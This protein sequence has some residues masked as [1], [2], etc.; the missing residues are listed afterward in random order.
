MIQ[1]IGEGRYRNEYLPKKAQD[2]DYVI[3]CKG[4]EIWSAIIEDQLTYLTYGEVTEKIPAL[5]GEETYLFAIDGISY[6][7]FREGAGGGLNIAGAFENAG[8]EGYGWQ[9]FHAVRYTCPGVG[10][11]A[12]ITAAQISQWY[13]NRRFCPHCGAPMEHSEKERM[14][15]CPSCKLT[16]YPKISP[17]VIVG[18]T[19]GDKILLTKYAGRS[20]TRYALIA[21]FYEVGETIEETVHREVMEEVGLRVKNLRYY[22]SQPWSVSDSLLMGFF[23]DVDG[24]PTIHLDE[25]ELSVGVWCSRDEIPEDDGISLTREMMTVFKNQK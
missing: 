25:E 7:L 1:D 13:S 22:K 9:N 19:N 24:D 8:F 4:R 6:F 23:C 15:R 21:G 20:Y 16:E 3:V 12:G 14:M 17:A 5:K 18:V 2:D 11:F 10:L